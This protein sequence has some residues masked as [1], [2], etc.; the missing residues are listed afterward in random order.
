MLRMLTITLVLAAAWTLSSSQ[1]RCE[2]WTFDKNSSDFCCETCSEGHYLVKK[3]GP[4][5]S[6]LCEP[7]PAKTYLNKSNSSCVPCRTCRGWQQVVMRQCTISSDTACGCTKGHH[8]AN[9]ECS[10]CV[11]CGVGE[12]LLEDDSC[13][14]CP[15]GTFKNESLSSC[16]PWSNSCPRQGCWIM[17]NGTAVSDSMCLACPKG[18]QCPSVPSESMTIIIIVAVVSFCLGLL[19]FCFHIGRFHVYKQEKKPPGPANA[20]QTL[21][22]Q[23]GQPE[24][25]QGGSMGSVSSEDSEKSLLSV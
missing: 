12:E 10:R 1:K 9:S 14:R 17:I 16:R 18:I 23:L 22:F 25:E 19:P 24:Q 21:T 3:C 5:P 13:H 20:P 4:K 15:Y 6:E 11:A 7:C 8:C 2:L